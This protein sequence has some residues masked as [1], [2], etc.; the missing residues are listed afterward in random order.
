[1]PKHC[2]NYPASN[3]GEIETKLSLAELHQGQE[4]TPDGE[5]WV[6]CLRGE[7]RRPA[8]GEGGGGQPHQG[9]GHH[10]AE[11]DVQGGSQ[12]SHVTADAVVCL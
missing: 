6:R 4:D 5:V 10:Q 7:V 3:R 12:G 1:M 8:A 2:P 9:E 11:G